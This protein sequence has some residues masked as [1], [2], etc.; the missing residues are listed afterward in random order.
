MRIRLV[1]YGIKYL[2]ILTS[3]TY[4]NKNIPW[5]KVLQP[6]KPPMEFS[7]VAL[8]ANTL[9]TNLGQLWMGV[10]CG[11]T[12]S[13]CPHTHSTNMVDLT[14]ASKNHRHHSILSTTPL[15]PFPIHPDARAVVRLFPGIVFF[16]FLVSYN[17]ERGGITTIIH[18]FHIEE[19]SVLQSVFGISCESCLMH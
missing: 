6:S 14:M 11:R 19:S 1:G 5:W 9:S 3:S 12:V 2:E 13:P 15:F 10:E 8:S 17:K 18:I 16:P 7:K 4:N